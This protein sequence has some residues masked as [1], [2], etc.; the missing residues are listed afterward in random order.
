MPVPAV[1]WTGFAYGKPGIQSRLLP[2]PARCAIEHGIA[3]QVRPRPGTESVRLAHLLVFAESV[4]GLENERPFPRLTRMRLEAE[5]QFP[6][7]PGT[8]FTDDADPTASGGRVR[9]A[10]VDF[11]CCFSYTA[12]AVS[13]SRTLSPRMR[14]KVDDNTIPNEVASLRVGCLSPPM[15]LAERSLRGT[16]FRRP[17]AGKIKY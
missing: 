10:A 3:I 7:N 12:A 6:L 9:R 8:P 16:D 15:P 1:P 4:P 17:A 13:T 11:P 2:L 5:K 14:L